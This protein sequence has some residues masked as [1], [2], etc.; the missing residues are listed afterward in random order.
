MSNLAYL[1]LETYFTVTRIKV[2]STVRPP[3]TP[4]FSTL[5]RNLSLCVKNPVEGNKVSPKVTVASEIGFRL[6]HFENLN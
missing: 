2:T 4:V 3:S 6:E 1:T 5:A